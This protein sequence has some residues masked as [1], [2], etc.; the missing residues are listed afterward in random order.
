MLPSDLFDK[1]DGE[2]GQIRLQYD[3][4]IAAEL[5]DR[6]REQ[7]DEAKNKRDGKR[8]VAERNKNRAMRMSGKKLGEVLKGTFDNE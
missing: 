6:I 4:A 2:G 5:S 3:L 7:T 8:A 1:Y